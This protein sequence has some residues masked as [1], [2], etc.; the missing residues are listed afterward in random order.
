MKE[1]C[2]RRRGRGGS[3]RLSG[4]GQ[5]DAGVSR[6]TAQEEGEGGGRWEEE[7]EQR[8]ERQQVGAKAPQE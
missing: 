4:T 3:K 2:E 5:E 6:Q 1:P 8:D 7:L